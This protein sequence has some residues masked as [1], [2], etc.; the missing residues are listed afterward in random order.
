MTVALRHSD[1]A[2]SPTGFPAAPWAIPSST[3]S[4]GRYVLRFA[5]TEG[6]LERVLRLR[7]EVI[8]RELGAGL[9]ASHAA[10]RDE[11]GFDRQFHHLL[12]EERESGAI[13]G[14]YRMQTGEMA[15][16]TGYS[17]EALFEVEGLPPAVRARAVELGRAC[18]AK[19]HRN[20]RVVHLLWRGLAG[21]LAWNRKSV[22]FGCCCLAS[23]DPGY[24]RALHGQLERQGSLHPSLRV[25]PRPGRGCGLLDSPH[26][27]PKLPS[28]FQAYLSLGARVLGP[29]ALDRDFKTIDWLVLL[30]AE[31]LD[32]F[33]Y[34][35]FFR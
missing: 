21:Y 4:A 14:T 24:G 15:A 31:E 29:P 18:I 28:L 23:Q 32:R 35:A 25:T 10:G 1:L 13:V 17:C 33:T 27:T 11:D 9:D 16:E 22:L 7:Y 30:D 2:S 6:E 12:I 8:N 3:I 5:R 19:A 20:G 26:P 34:Q